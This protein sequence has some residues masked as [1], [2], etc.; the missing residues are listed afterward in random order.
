MK[1]GILSFASL[2]FL[3]V[4][5]NAQEIKFEEYDLPNGLHVILHQ[6]NSSPLVT[7]SVYYSVGSKD[8]A[9]GRTGFAHFF[10]HLLFEGTKNIKRGDWSKIVSSNGGGNNATTDND[11]TYYYEDFPSNNEQLGL[12]M[13]A[14]RMRH[15]VIS[16]IGVDTQREVVKEEKRLRF[17]NRP[18][19]NLFTAITQT[20]FPNSQYG[21]TPIGSMDDL[22]SAKLEE[23]QDFYKKFYIPNN[24]VLVV[25]GDIKPAQTKKWINDY[26][27][28]IPKGAT[29]IRNFTED[30]PIT[31]E[32]SVTFTD[33]NIQLPM[34]LYSYRTP[35]NTTRDSKVMDLVSSYLSGGKSSVLYKK[36]VDQD[37]KA[38]QVSAES[39][40]FEKA[41]FFAC[42]A[43]P[44]GKT[45]EGEL[46][47]VI[48]S[49]IKK[50]QTDL[51]SDEDLQKLQNKFE[52]QFVN[53]N[54]NIHSRAES[55]ATYYALTGNTNLINKEIDIYR[56]ITKEDIRN[57]ARKY[58]NPNQRIIINYVPEKK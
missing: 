57:A 9:K 56:G 1:K 30:T 58:L 33:P 26:F 6:D 32:K 43:I 23:F 55:L 49:E 51:I 10:E 53:Q 35:G 3:G 40:A 39:L 24:A 41:G 22:N 28:T 15:A 46:R 25:A 21:W 16:Q 7:T 38:L 45:P 42:L 11:R 18:Y 29:I 37:K 31:Q 20:M 54:S 5:M 4:L 48:D 47:S 12:W 14:E 44:M 36:L 19:G 27:S 17:D 52:N 8:E 34:Y 13:E 50:L 2:A